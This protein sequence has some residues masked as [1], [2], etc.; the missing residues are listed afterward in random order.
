LVFSMESESRGSPFF[1]RRSKFRQLC[2]HYNVASR[3]AAHN[4]EDNYTR[5]RVVKSFQVQILS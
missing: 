1:R 3:E 5:G 2:A 4:K